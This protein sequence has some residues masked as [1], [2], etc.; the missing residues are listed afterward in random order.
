MHFTEATIEAFRHSIAKRYARILYNN[1]LRKAPMLYP[2]T[3]M[4]AGVPFRSADDQ[5]ILASMTCD[6][7][8]SLAGKEPGTVHISVIK[9]H[10]ED[11]FYVVGQIKHG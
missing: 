7:L 6:H 11:Y 1:H 5:N 2:L 3:S 10:K 8:A 4:L 9:H